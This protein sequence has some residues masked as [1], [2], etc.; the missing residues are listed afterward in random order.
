ME[1][2]AASPAAA[3]KISMA[4]SVA[5]VSS[6]VVGVLQLQGR[7]R[8]AETALLHAKKRCSRY[9]NT[10]CSAVYR[11]MSWIDGSTSHR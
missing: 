10:K 11:R 2:A 3:N 5:A 1:E 6:R 9:L 7:Q 8:T 4:A